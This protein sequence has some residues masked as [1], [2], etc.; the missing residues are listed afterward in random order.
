MNSFDQRAIQHAEYLIY[1]DLAALNA[2]NLGFEWEKQFAILAAQAN[3]AAGS[4][5][6]MVSGTWVTIAAIAAI[7]R[8]TIGGLITKI[9]KYNDVFPYDLLLVVKSKN[10]ATDTEG[11][12]QTVVIDK[13]T[14]ISAAGT[15]TFSLATQWLNHQKIIEVYED[16]DASG[17]LN[18]G[19][20]LL[21]RMVTIAPKGGMTGLV[22]ECAR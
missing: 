4:L 10:E 9:P 18:S 16:R 21:A 3:A 13:D 17:A 2:A 19:D 1:T 14:D 11:I 8:G 12:E 7:A 22:V 15:A 6:M 20:R 5:V